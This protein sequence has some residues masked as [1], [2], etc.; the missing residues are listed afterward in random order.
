MWRRHSMINMQKISILLLGLL[1]SASLPA[2]RN[3][4]V[5]FQQD[6]DS[7]VDQ[8]ITLERDFKPVIQDAGKIYSAPKVYEPH[9][10]NEMRVDYT[11]YSKLLQSDYNVNQL[12]FA[13]SRFMRT[14]DNY[15]GFLKAAAGYPL[16]ALDFYYKMKE[17]DKVAFDIHFNHLGQWAST[18]HN[19]AGILARSGG[20][21]N[22]DVLFGSN[23]AFNIGFDAVNLTSKRYYKGA[24][25]DFDAHIGVH[26]LPAAPITYKV[27]FGYRGFSAKN[28]PIDSLLV[29]PEAAFPVL[30]NQILTIAQIDYALDAHHIGLNANIKD[31]FYSS[32]DTLFQGSNFNTMHFEP[33]Y[34]YQSNKVDVHAGVNLDISLNK[35]RLFAASPNITFETRLVQE[36]LAIYGGATG[37]YGVHGLYEDVTNNHYVNILQAVHDTVNSYNVADAFLGLKVRPHYDLLIKFYAHFLYTIDDHYYI[38]DAMTHQ[39]SSIYANS[40]EW[41]IGASVHYHYRDIATL[42]VDGFYRLH[43]YNSDILPAALD[44]PSWQILIDVRAKLDKDKKWTLF[45]ENY[46]IGG[47]NALVANIDPADPTLTDVVK[48]KP[49][50]DLNIGVEYAID[51]N[52]AAFVKLSDYIH[53]GKFKNYQWYDYSTQ[54]GNIVAGVSWTF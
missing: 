25:W 6:R 51:R 49:I 39:F 29:L 27:Q 31:H 53:W 34:S 24:Y 37:N 42:S 16:T 33:Y 11:E 13:E 50:I 35:G 36:W 18:K 12:T 20:G 48:L 44:R 8:H 28:T 14:V 15:N 46:L 17:I 32:K 26:S 40:N 4:D 23:S 41:K 30:D 3:G 7:V 43:N 1:L 10:T 2:Q 38:A 21:F 45:S 9:E 22:V 19:G 47:R 5:T 52:F 54:G